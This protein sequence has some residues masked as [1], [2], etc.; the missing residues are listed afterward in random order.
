MNLLHH[1]VGPGTA[2]SPSRLATLDAVWASLNRTA[3]WIAAVLGPVS[4]VAYAVGLQMTGHA[5]MI[6]LV[7]AGTAISVVAAW[8]LRRGHDSLEAVLVL[9]SIGTVA[10]AWPAPPVVRGMLWTALAVFA[11]AA[12][13]L[14]SRRSA[15]RT[16]VVISLLAA[17]PVAWP[18]FG[19]ASPGEAALA[20]GVAGASIFFGVLSVS[21]ARR[22]LEESESSRI[23]IFRRVPVGLFR[24]TP[25][26]HFLDAN[27]A[28]LEILGHEPGRDLSELSLP[29][30]YADPRE[31]REYLKNLAESDGP[32]RFAVR[33]VRVDGSTIWVRG[34]AQVV[35]G[36]DGTSSY[37]EG[38]IEDITQRREAEQASRR[39]EQRFRTLFDAAPIGLV[40]EDFSAV[41]DRFATLRETGVTDLAAHLARSPL[42]LAELV[43]RIHV[44]DVNPAGI[45]L[46]GATSKQEA[47][48]EL[49]HP[50]ASLMPAYEERFTSLWRDED[51]GDV[52]AVLARPDGIDQ[53]VHLHWAMS[54]SDEGVD[55]SR[56]V[57]AIAD[58]TALR[59]AERGLAELVRSKDEIVA[60]VSH[61]LRTPITTIMGMS[62]EL[63]DN[64]DLLTPEERNEFVGLIADQSRELS[65]IVEDLL[66]AARVDQDRLVI[67][68]EPVDLATEVPRIVSSTTTGHRA[69]VETPH[70]P[71]V[72]WCDPL[73]VRQIIRNLLTNADRYGGDTV[74]V[75]VAGTDQRVSIRVCDDGDGVAPHQREAIFEPYHRAD[76]AG[77]PGAIGLGL[78]VSRKLARLMGGDLVYVHAEG[79]TVFELVLPAREP[80]RPR[81]I[82]PR[83]EVPTPGRR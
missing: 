38:T 83:R 79:E 62:L 6:V 66:V 51:R 34:H 10:G 78:P 21:M 35:A 15:R 63:R 7:A 3:L 41:R 80:D 37:L 31:G 54:R 26:G 69:E 45:D 47:I 48:E 61:E 39:H 59:A 74:R 18:A 75:E 49:R 56:V 70:G 68:A 77:L 30:L 40:E 36:P 60:S 19:L 73:R 8:N 25:D 17:T 13:L 32:Q 33:M 46:V 4:V 23:A 64:A 14:L 52:D 72:A 57:M 42:E 76:E 20:L 2:A 22:A 12:A 65:N 29:E 27:P 82:R 16:V 53:Y 11:V 1:R 9:A 5:G 67:R 28:M 58:V 50:S 43:R 24:A 44:I 71:H 55:P 81:P